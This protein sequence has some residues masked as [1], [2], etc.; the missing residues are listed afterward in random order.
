MSS[1]HEVLVRIQAILRKEDVIETKNRTLKC[2][3]QYYSTVQSMKN[4]AVLTK[5]RAIALFFHSHPIG[6]D[7][8]WIPTPGNLPSKAKKMLM[9]GVSAGGWAQLQLT[10][11]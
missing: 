2:W 10:D 7:S 9:H 1:L 5:D 4:V 3:E 6:F 8:S 11:A